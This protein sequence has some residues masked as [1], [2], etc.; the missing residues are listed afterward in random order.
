MEKIY[1]KS[2]NLSDKVEDLIRS[3][4]IPGD[5]VDS[6][7]ETSK[8]IRENDYMAI[9]VSKGSGVRAFGVDPAMVPMDIRISEGEEIDP[10]CYL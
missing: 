4:R 3:G 6:V 1:L 5:F 9:I 8:R 10:S 7:R 2:N